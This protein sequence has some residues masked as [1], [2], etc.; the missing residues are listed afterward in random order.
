M[1]TAHTSAPLNLVLVESWYMGPGGCALCPFLRKWR[2][3]PGDDGRGGAVVPSGG[4]ATASVKSPRPS[5]KCMYFGAWS[6]P[7]AGIG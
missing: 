5:L 6:G 4:A 2:G 7:C 1:L 3:S